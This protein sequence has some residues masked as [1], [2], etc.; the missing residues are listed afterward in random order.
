MHSCKINGYE[1]L[2]VFDYLLQLELDLT[3][4]NTARNVFAVE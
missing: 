2:N 4:K 3:A 1:S